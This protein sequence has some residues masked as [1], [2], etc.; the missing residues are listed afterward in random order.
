MRSSIDFLIIP[1]AAPLRFSFTQ[2]DPANPYQKYSFCLEATDDEL[3][4]V[5]DCQPPVLAYETVHELVAPLNDTND[6]MSFV[7]GMRRAFLQ[8]T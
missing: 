6:M 1:N 4:S 5:V 3:W 2:L 8:H 7:R